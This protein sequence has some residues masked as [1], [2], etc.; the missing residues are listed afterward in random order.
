MASPRQGS[1]VAAGTR[2][3]PTPHKADHTVEPRTIYPSRSGPRSAP[4]LPTR[5]PEK[6]Q[7]WPPTPR[8][9]VPG[10][11]AGGEHWDTGPFVGVEKGPQLTHQITNVSRPQEALTSLE[12][13]WDLSP[14]HSSPACSRRVGSFPG[15]LLRVAPP[16][17]SGPRVPDPPGLLTVTEKSS[18]PAEHTALLVPTKAT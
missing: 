1:G 2:P 15:P 12:P 6:Q 11:P 16:G 13:L 14:G 3:G 9:S 17:W 8:P 18:R 10:A 5:R 7:V 4:P